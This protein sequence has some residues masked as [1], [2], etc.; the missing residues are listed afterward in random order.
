MPRHPSCAGIY[1][2]IKTGKTVASGVAHPSAIFIAAPGALN[3]LEGVFGIPEP[4]SHD[5]ETFPEVTAFV[6]RLKPGPEAI[7]I[8]DASVIADR[9]AAVM[10][11]KF[12]HSDNH[13]ASWLATLK[14]S[15][16]SRDAIRRC[17]RHSVWTMHEVPPEEKGARILGGPRFPG[18]A[19]EKIPAAFDVLFRA[20]PRNGLEP[21]PKRAWKFVFQTKPNADYLAGDRYHVAADPSPMNLGE[22]LRL[23]GYPLPRLKGL[24]WQEEWVRSI[25]AILLRTDA[26][27]GLWLANAERAEAVLEEAERKLT[28]KGYDE[29]HIKWTL[30]DG[31]DRAVLLNARGRLRRGF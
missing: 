10:A 21:A 13:F 2:P 8:D 23:A 22:I 15:I 20:V 4:E 7:I 14:A 25:A 30:T 6:E 9:T 31:Y 19:R 3:G 24:E 27:V 11:D 12:K 28:A 29:R 5:L 17:R 16:D 1:A 26:T 18:Q